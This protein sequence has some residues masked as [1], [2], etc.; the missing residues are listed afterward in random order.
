MGICA[1]SVSFSLLIISFQIFFFFEKV[2]PFNLLTEGRIIFWFAELIT[3]ILN[4]VMYAVMIIQ[5]VFCHQ[6]KQLWLYS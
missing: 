6:C 2:F 3:A 5:K 1:L 4:F